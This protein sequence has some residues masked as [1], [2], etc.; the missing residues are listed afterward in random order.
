MQ[1]K[2][3]FFKIGI[4]IIGITMLICRQYNHLV[5]KSQEIHRHYIKS[6]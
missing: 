6:N 2:G 3:N 4:E 1:L 5:K